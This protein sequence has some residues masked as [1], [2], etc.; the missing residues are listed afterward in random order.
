LLGCCK[1]YRGWNSQQSHV[2]LA[3]EGDSLPAFAG[4]LGPA[5]LEA[6]ERGFRGTAGRL[7][8]IIQSRVVTTY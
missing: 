7:S 3:S 5:G 4:E 1:L 8:V 6:G 2:E